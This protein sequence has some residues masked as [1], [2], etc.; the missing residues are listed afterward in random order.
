MKEAKITYAKMSQLKDSAC[1]K[2]AR[3]MILQA[4]I[5]GMTCGYFKGHSIALSA[6]GPC[7]MVGK[8]FDITRNLA[9]QLHTANLWLS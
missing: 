8:G 1:T 5:D 6:I 2:S 9:G 4:V 7:V 3:L